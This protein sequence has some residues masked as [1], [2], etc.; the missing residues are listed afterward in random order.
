[1]EQVTHALAPGMGQGFLPASVTLAFQRMRQTWRMLFLVALGMLAAVV[2]VCAVPLYSQVAMTAGLRSALTA[3]G[4]STDIVVRGSTNSISSSTVSTITGSLNQEFQHN[5]GPYLLPEQFEFQA[6]PLNIMAP[7]AHGALAVTGDS[8]EMTGTDTTR[9]ASHLR[10]TQGRM[11]SSTIHGNTIEIAIRA[12]IAANLGWGP[13]TVI[14]LRVVHLSTD[15]NSQIAGMF[16]LQIVGVFTPLK[17]DDP[18]WHGEDFLGFAAANDVN[19]VAGSLV[20]NAAL[21]S[22]FSQAPA[23]AQPVSTTANSL[24]WYYSLNPSTIQV[25]QVDPILNAIQTVQVDISNNTLLNDPS[26]SIQRVQTYLPSSALNLYHDRLPIVQFPVTSL[27]LLVLCLALFF[28][29]LMTGI[30]VERQ[31]GAMA[32]LRSRGASARQIFWSLVTQAVVLGLVAL[33]AGPLLSIVVVRLLAQHIL[34]VADLGALNIVGGNPLPIVQSV[35]IYALATTGAMVLTMILAIWSTASRDV[36]ALRRETARSTHRPF[37]QRLNLD[38]VAIVIALLCAGF[39]LYLSNSSA[40][41]SRS[42]LLYLSPLTLLEAICILLA[43]MLLLLRG[44]PWLLRGGAWL[45]ARLRGATSLVA[46]AQM[47]RAPR[48]SIRMTLLLALATA[49]TIFTLVFNASQTQRIQDVSDYQAMADFSGNVPIAVIPP[50]QLA[51]MTQAYNHLPGVLASSLGYVKTATAGGAALSLQID[52]KAVDAATFAQTAR[53][54]TLDSTQTLPALMHQLVAQRSLATSKAVVPALVDAA[55]WNE[56]HLSPG[57]NFTLNFSLVGNFDLVNFRA[58]A[59]VQDI[60]TSGN[61]SI[62]GVLADYTSFVSAYTHNFTTGSGLTVP[63]NYV[64]LRTSDNPTQLGALRRQL[65]QG[66]LYLSPLYDRRQMAQQLADEPLYLTLFGILLLGT[67]TALLLAL[68][69]NLVASWLNA[70]SRLANFAALRALGATPSQIAGTLAWEQVIIY[71]TAILLGFF[72]GWL[73]AILVL[74][75]LV[76]TSILPSQITGSVDS[77]T[78]YAAQSTPPIQIVIPAALWLALGVLI[79]LCI[80]ALGMMVRIVSRPSI[81]Q[82]LRLNED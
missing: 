38:I 1:M 19:F 12:E 50:Q 34:T 76:F 56:L 5:L 71:T 28:V 6:A 57:A 24:I 42:R 20:S 46:L 33:L 79:A 35:G 8:I 66:N 65:T 10:F 37:W 63:L 78:F 18:F 54:S 75:S 81:A 64:W 23:G 16:M 48:Q 61:S 22:L 52:F 70:S 40:L 62:P 74:P 30:L 36:L 67:A 45:T 77:Q 49:F 44:F 2:V 17:S 7:D 51:T 11:P 43:A 29:T 27:T 4:Q 25:S 15:G 9:A 59:E 58:V 72:F 60:P 3:S 73:L 69:G 68:L 31:S 21:I 53:W 55:T 80:V 47:S 41:D 82:V 13:G 32:I 26:S 14:P 39:A